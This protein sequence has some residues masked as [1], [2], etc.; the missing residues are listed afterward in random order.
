[1]IKMEK[2]FYEIC[3]EIAMNVS[4]GS[5]GCPFSEG[6]ANAVGAGFMGF[7]IGLGLFVGFLA[8]IA[9]Y[10]Y[11]SLA[12]YKIGKKLKYKNNWLAWIPIVRWAMI[13]QM[14]GFHWAWVFLVLIPVVGWISLFVILII[15][16]WGIY[17]RC[18]YPGWFSLAMIIPEIGGILYL[19][20]IGFVAWGSGMEGQGGKKGR[21]GK[22][23]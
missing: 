6:T 15:A 9:I 10:V 13:L 1:M 18:R 5:Q 8:V 17:K 3:K 20:A 14:G 19:I 4:E 21:K 11:T 2:E 12:W 16:S 22:K 23:K 7:L